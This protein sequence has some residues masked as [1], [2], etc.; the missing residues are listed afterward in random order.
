MIKVR[1]TVTPTVTPVTDQRIA[2]RGYVTPGAT[3][4]VYRHYDAD[5][6]L[7]YVGASVSPIARAEEHASCAAWYRQIARIDLQWF[8]T[9][10]E[11]IDAE[12][13]AIRD[14]SPKHNK[15]R[16]GAISPHDEP[17]S[18]AEATWLIGRPRIYLTAAEKQRAYRARKKARQ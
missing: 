6:V 12:R 2:R 14:E 1:E 13:R 4:C 11:A 3:T 15:M 18:N 7:L 16:Y 9:Y 17:K 5:D 10:A 8:A